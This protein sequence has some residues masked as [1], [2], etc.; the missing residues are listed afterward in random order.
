MRA[1]CRRR[2]VG[3][4]ASSVLTDKTGSRALAGGDSSLL[5]PTSSVLVNDNLTYTIRLL[6]SGSLPPHLNASSHYNQA[7][8]MVFGEPRG[9]RRTAL[10]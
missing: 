1:R 8:K 2:E 10:Y 7:P 5:R 9:V 3:G 4:R 6:R